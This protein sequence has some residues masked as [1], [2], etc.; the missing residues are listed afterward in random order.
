MR[1]KT[2]STK[3][4]DFLQTVISENF[5]DLAAKIKNLCALFYLKYIHELLEKL[6]GIH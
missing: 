6:H 3:N 5:S 4:Q 1:R 2:I